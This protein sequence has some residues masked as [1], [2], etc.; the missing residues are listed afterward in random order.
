ME[1]ASQPLTAEQLSQAVTC[2]HWVDGREYV[3]HFPLSEL[4]NAIAICG[5]MITNHLDRSNPAVHDEIAR[6]AEL[7]HL[8]ILNARKWFAE[9]ASEPYRPERM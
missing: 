4:A 1:T 8:A 3:L 2:P 6:L 7:P 9:Y 5:W